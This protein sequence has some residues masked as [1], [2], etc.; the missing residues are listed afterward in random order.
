MEMEEKDKAAEKIKMIRFYGLNKPAIG[1]TGRR[2]CYRDEAT[3]EF[4]ELADN[5]V[6]FDWGCAPGSKIPRPGANELAKGLCLAALRKPYETDAELTF[7]VNRARAVYMRFRQRYVDAFPDDWSVTD[8][9][10]LRAIESI[11]Q[12]GEEAR[13]DMRLGRLERMPTMTDAGGPTSLGGSIVW[14]TDIDGQMIVPKDPEDF[15]WQPAPHAR[16]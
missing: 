13:R 9:D 4:C 7:A 11:E 16:R 12:D 3:N 5:L 10:I 1:R 8:A 6:A 14:D 2:V 15:A